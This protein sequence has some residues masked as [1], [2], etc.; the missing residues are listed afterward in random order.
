MP[1]P[2]DYPG[3]P[4]DTQ[5]PGSLTFQKTKGLVGL[6]QISLR[7]KWTPGPSCRHP[8]EP[9]STIKN[10]EHHPVVYSAY[11]DAKSYSAWAGKV[12]P[13]E[14]DWEFA[15]HGGFDGAIFL[16]GDDHFPNNQPAANIW[17]GDFLWQKLEL[18]GFIGTSPVGSFPANGYEL[19]DT[20]ENVGK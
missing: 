1:K 7:W 19:Y 14:A 9:C 8:E 3:V 17:Q 20:A 16:L 10:R 12:L 6:R 2:K 13:S 18:D 11:E 5:V 15:T 4:P